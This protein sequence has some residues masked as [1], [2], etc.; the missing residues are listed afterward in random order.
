[1]LYFDCHG[2][3]VHCLITL[4]ELQLQEKPT[5]YRELHQ[6]TKSRNCDVSAGLAPT[7]EQHPLSDCI[8]KD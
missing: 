2:D 8:L 3:G 4:W 5:D 6:Y 1:M 7:V